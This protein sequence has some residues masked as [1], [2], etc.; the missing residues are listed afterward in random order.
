[1]ATPTSD[2]G[3]VVTALFWA[4][5]LAIPVSV[6]AAGIEYVSYWTIPSFPVVAEGDPLFA[7]D[8]ETGYVA[9]PNSSTKWTMLGA[10]GRVNVQYHVYTDQRGARV[11]VPG[12]RS[13]DHFDILML[14]DSFAWGHGVENEDTFASKTIAALGGSGTNLA[15]ASYG[16]TQSLQLLRRYRGLAPRLVIFELNVDHLWRNVS[17]C[18]RSAYPF[19]MD[20]AHVAWDGQG[21]L[22][23]ARP[24][25]DGVTRLRLHLRAERG[26][27]DPL[28]WI[29]HG[30]D[31]AVARVRS[32]MANATATDKTKQN[33]ALEFLIEQMARTAHEMNAALLIVFLPEESMSP[34]PEFL[35][36]SAAQLRYSFLDLR[37]VFMKIDAAARQDLFLKNEG[38]PSAAGHALIAQELIAFIRR[39]NLLAQLT[40]RR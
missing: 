39:E 26:G 23:I 33:T 3:R 9:R 12:Q 8:A 28:T 40:L 13:A 1:M 31:V 22:Y 27:L 21:H 35:S 30:L 25:S 20:S 6:L 24:W 17:P 10:D 38:H 37:P 36:R 2:R 4:A 5:M 29:I 14:G 19:C 16:T 7:F 34:P 18:T 15:L 11:A 32:Q